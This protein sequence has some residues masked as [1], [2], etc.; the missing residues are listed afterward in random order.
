MPAPLLAPVLTA[1]LLAISASEQEVVAPF[2]R[3]PPRR[4]VRS[5]RMGSARRKAVARLAWL[6]SESQGWATWKEMCV[7]ADEMGV[8]TRHQTDNPSSSWLFEEMSESYRRPTDPIPMSVIQSRPHAAPKRTIYQ[9]ALDSMWIRHRIRFPMKGTRKK[10]YIY[11]AHPNASRLAVEHEPT[12]K[13]LQICAEWKKRG[14][15]LRQILSD[16]TYHSSLID[17]RWI[18]G[19]IHEFDEVKVI[20]DEPA[21]KL[22]LSLH[23]RPTDDE[24]LA[25]RWDQ[26]ISDLE[27]YFSMMGGAGGGRYQTILEPDPVEPKLHV[28]TSWP[29]IETK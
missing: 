13:D 20:L 14:K 4:P 19:L 24:E 29:Q 18:R 17:S 23:P 27:L 16:W 9:M 10:Q 3:P 12:E 26:D 2:F 22:V 8:R 21:D 15:L 1:L 5:Y 11:L 6:L 28:W 25:A 7:L